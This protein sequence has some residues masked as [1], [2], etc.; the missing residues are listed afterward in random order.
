MWWQ[1]QPFDGAVVVVAPATLALV[2]PV[3]VSCAVVVVAPAAVLAPAAVVVVAPVEVSGAVV[4][5]APTTAVVVTV[6]VSD[7]VVP[8]PSA[9]AAATPAASVAI[10]PTSMSIRLMLSLT[11]VLAPTLHRE[12]ERDNRPHEVSAR[13]AQGLRVRFPTVSARLTSAEKPAGD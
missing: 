10:A 9:T 5:V 2:V 7:A 8:A 3:E 13:E 12:L 6:E 4:V 1:T 11:R